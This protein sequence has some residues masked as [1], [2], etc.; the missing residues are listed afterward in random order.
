MVNL[1]YRPLWD[2]QGGFYMPEKRIRE[3]NWKAEGMPLLKI[4]GLNKR[5]GT[6]AILQGIDLDI[7]DGDRIGLVGYNGAGK[8]TLANILYGKSSF[9]E[10]TIHFERKQVKIG[11][12]LQSVEYSVNDFESFLSNG[13]GNGL[14]EQ[15]SQLGLEK[16]Q[17]WNGEKLGNLS[18]GE[19]L[20]LALSHVLSSKPDFLILDEP[21][22]HLDLKGMNWL[23]S[24]LK[25][26]SGAVLVI[27]HDRYFLDRTVSRICELEDGCIKQYSGNYSFYRAEKKRKL[28][29][30]RHQYEVQQNYKRK[31]EGQIENLSSW[32]EKAHRESTKKGGTPSER[33]QIGF[34]EYNRKKAKKMDVQIRSKMKRLEQEL[35]KNRI[36]K[37]KEE[38]RVRFEF[39]GSGKRGKRIIEA[40]GISKAY[41]GKQLFKDS[42]FYIKYGEKMGI[43]GENGCGK[44][45]FLN[46][47]LDQEI[48]TEGELWKSSSLK[49]AYL[50]QE[51][52]DLPDTLTPLEAL[53]VF[54][55]DDVHRARTMLANVGLD[56]SKIAMPIAGL[57]LGER[58][59]IKLVG[60]LLK[61]YDVLI[62]DEPTNHLDL[63]TREQLELTLSEFSGTIIAVSHD[64]YFLDKL[65]DKLLVFEGGEIKRV[66]ASISQYE[67]MKKAPVRALDDSKERLLII[68][69]RIAS[70]LGELSAL[71]PQDERYQELDLEFYELTKRKRALLNK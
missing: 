14:L 67:E 48:L 20:K 28:E 66:E 26:Y 61:E 56:E 13:Y 55:A 63:P 38:S 39:D 1:A 15:A 10:G 22:N 60:M 43:A 54:H 44:T 70:I 7:R 50:S 12:L 2:S 35:E 36:E 25:S 19:R 18:G 21:T 53:E 37:P 65:C 68:E 52:S 64:Y 17:S 23:V 30:Q 24:A 58:T 3:K 6:K 59:R 51:V 40:K 49:I 8:T 71:S 47:L 69:T 33:R 42:H 11:Y 27:S 29:V 62:L 45:T 31:I 34:K 5:F 4:R 32:S 16:V 57:S 9:D 46:I 41:P